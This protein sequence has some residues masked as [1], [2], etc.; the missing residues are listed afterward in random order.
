MCAVVIE[1]NRFPCVETVFLCRVNGGSVNIADIQFADFLQFI[2]IQD[3]HIDTATDGKH[4][5]RVAIFIPGTFFLVAFC[6]SFVAS[7]E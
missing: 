4:L 3:Q 2:A 1:K 5:V 7:P 6:F